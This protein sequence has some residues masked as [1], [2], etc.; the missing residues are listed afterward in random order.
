MYSLEQKDIRRDAIASYVKCYENIISNLCLSLSMTSRPEYLYIVQQLERISLLH[1]NRQLNNF[2]NLWKNFP[3]KS[4]QT[5]R[6]HP[7]S[8][9]L[10]SSLRYGYPHYVWLNRFDGT[11]RC[12][13][14]WSAKN[15]IARVCKC[16][17]SKGQDCLF[18]MI[19][20]LTFLSFGYSWGRI[21]QI[22]GHSGFGRYSDV[23]SY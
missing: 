11:G 4:R 15:L 7:E 16:A 9:S 2:R 12:W 20:D 23:Q 21:T 5:R 3:S 22:V 1:T 14:L 10:I 19:S 17:S 6:F 13:S 8:T 18:G